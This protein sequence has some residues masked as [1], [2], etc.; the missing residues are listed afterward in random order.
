MRSLYIILV[1]VFIAITAYSKTIRLRWDEVNDV[2]LTYRVH[3]GTTSKVYTDFIDAGTRA[4]CD[5]E[6]LQDSTRYYFS[7]TAVDFWG[8]ESSFSNE[9]ISAGNQAPPQVSAKFDLGFNYPNPFNGDTSFG[10]TL[11]EESD[12]HLAVYNSIGQKIKIVADG[13]FQA[14]LHK[15]S[16]N[17]DNAL[18]GAVSSGT[19]LC[20]LEIGA[21]RLTRT[22]TLLR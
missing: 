6:N 16:W 14:G 15:A 17:G 22:I 11:P 12:I 3:W 10:F 8:N 21:I 19:Y 18:G 4:S 20:V 1:A 5:I 7:V 9:V 13:Q 2:I